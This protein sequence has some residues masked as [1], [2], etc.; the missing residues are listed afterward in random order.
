M[1][2]SHLRS[3]AEGASRVLVV[4]DETPI[5]RAVRRVLRKE[6][7][8][9]I[10][11]NSPKEALE[12]LGEEPYAVLLAD[13][14]M[15]DME[16]TYLLEKARKLSPSTI[17]IILTGYLDPQVAIAAINRGAV[18]AFVTK[19]WKD[20]DLCTII[21]QAVA[22]FQLQ[23]QNRQLTQDLAQ[24]RE[25]EVRIAS[26]IQKLLLAGQVPNDIRGMR[27]SALT[28]PS[29]QV[30]GDFYDF[31]QHGDDC[32]DV[33]VG[34]VM[35]KGIP[36]ALL[37]AATKN[38]FLH[39]LHQTPPCIDDS[40]PSPEAVVDRVHRCLTPQL[41]QLESFVTICYARFDLGRGQVTYV[42]CG[43]TKTIHMKPSVG[44]CQVLQGD[45]MPLGFSMSETYRQVTAPF[46][47][48][49]TF[50]FYSDG[51]S[52]AHLAPGRFFGKA[53]LMDLVKQ[54][55]AHGPERLVEEIHKR[56]R[57]FMSG[58]SLTDDLTCVALQA[59]PDEV[60]YDD[61]YRAE[62]RAGNGTR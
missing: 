17:R 56:V 10:V 20:E 24:A 33:I 26:R 16:G 2:E 42:D 34:D 14:R 5:L 25:Q 59:C 35:G 27:V 46:G 4:D 55:H 44:D 22:Q 61:D 18:F 7:F 45:N 60:Q 41:I 30:D 43:H 23:K 62:L 11:T 53:H 48:A 38:Q 31:I 36:A 50:L 58:E 57:H 52:E 13:H 21:R 1:I 19:P 6:N 28:V 39:A 49:D 8:E 40:Q 47:N 32:L 54:H 9:V 3:S 51:V 29:Q 15:P 37:G 12:L